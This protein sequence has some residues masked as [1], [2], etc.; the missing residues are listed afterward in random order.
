M[1]QLMRSAEQAACD[2]KR[3]LDMEARSS[4]ENRQK[5]FNEQGA[6]GK[7]AQGVTWSYVTLRASCRHKYKSIVS[8]ALGSTPV[9]W[10]ACLY[11]LCP[12]LL[13][14]HHTV[15]VTQVV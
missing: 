12:S 8:C 7:G 6:A 1:F 13:E 3:L 2:L 4:E 10:T 15:Y 11:T 9:Q 5:T 14:D